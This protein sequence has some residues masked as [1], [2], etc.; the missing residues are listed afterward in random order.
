MCAFDY[1]DGASR[2]GRALS[3]YCNTRCDWQSSSSRCQMQDNS[4]GKIHGVLLGDAKAIPIPAP[5]KGARFPLTARN[6]RS[7]MPARTSANDLT[8]TSTVRG[9]AVPKLDFG[10]VINATTEGRAMAVELYHFWSSVC[11]VRCRM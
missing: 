4:T 3:K 5:L 8:A 6:G 11:S 7:I 9:R 10:L 2:G 1:P